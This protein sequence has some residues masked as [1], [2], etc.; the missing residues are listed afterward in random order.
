VAQP[1]E[2]S[3][4][5]TSARRVADEW[6]LV[7]VAEGLEPTLRPV[8]G[9]YELSVPE[10][11]A[12][13]AAD[14]LRAYA[15]ESS[16]APAAA[17]PAWRGDGPLALGLAAAGAL[18]AFHLVT[19]PR[20]QASAWFAAGAAD[21]GAIAAGEAWRAVTALTLHADAAHL[22]GN[23]LAGAL[24]LTLVGRA[25]GP[26]CGAL[27]VLAAGACGN[28]ANALLRAGDHVSVG[29]ST[30]VFGAVGI[31]AGL[32]AAR[33]RLGLGRRPAWVLL[34][35]SLGLLAMLGT[36]GERTD[37]WAH[38]LGL[39]AGL[40]I[41]AGLGAAARQPPGLSAQLAC[42]ALGAA[43]VVGSWLRAI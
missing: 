13:R 26:G 17:E 35:A 16:A 12:A 31:L 5:R 6:A 9:D 14:L 3:I 20:A 15:G 23:A 7:L 1:D 8:G 22:F 30:A 21:A 27:A 41:G 33:R 36:S 2:R 39:G 10:A 37:I 38:A 25:L 34:A 42:G 32:G 18:V 11:Q 28:L 43:L 24:M 40:A 29:A 19:G 4:A